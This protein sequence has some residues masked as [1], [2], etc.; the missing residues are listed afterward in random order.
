[1][2]TK[3]LIT[4]LKN[5][6]NIYLSSEETQELIKYLDEDGSGDIDFQ[7]FCNK[8]NFNDL[9]Q[10]SHQYTISKTS[11]MDMMLREWDFYNK[12]ENGKIMDLFVKFDDNG[13]GVLVLDEFESLL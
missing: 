4:G 5:S 9:Q 3:E 12:R 1:M 6:F 13:D 8:I 10:K 7:E 2:D 11:F